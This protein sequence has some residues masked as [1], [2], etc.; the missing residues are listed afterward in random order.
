MRRLQRGNCRFAL[1]RSCVRIT[2]CQRQ[3]DALGDGAGVLDARR[4]LSAVSRLLVRCCQHQRHH[5]RSRERRPGMDD[6]E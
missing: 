1:D 3:R 4:I 5:Q 2:L 6:D